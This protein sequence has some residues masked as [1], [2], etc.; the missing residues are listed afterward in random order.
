[1][2]PF[3]VHDYDMTFSPSDNTLRWKFVCRCGDEVST[4]A[5]A[6]ARTKASKALSNGFL[7]IVLCIFTSTI[8]MVSA[9]L[10]V[11]ALR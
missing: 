8:G 11:G 7:L 3:H 1:M 5:E 10:I 9:F 6:Q 4:M 2:K